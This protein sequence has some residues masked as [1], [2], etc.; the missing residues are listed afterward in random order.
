VIFELGLFMGRLGTD[1]A[2][3]MEPRNNKVRLPSDL[4]GVTTITYRFDKNNPDKA[5]LLAP[6]CNE[7]RDYIV[8]KGPKKDW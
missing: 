2:I 4:A 8:N 7:L 3:L 1:R 6:A 5:A